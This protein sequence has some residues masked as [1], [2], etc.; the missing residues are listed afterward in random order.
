MPEMSDYLNT[1][2]TDKMRESRCDAKNFKDQSS[3]P[4]TC[5]RSCL[6]SLRRLKTTTDGTFLIG[7]QI[8]FFTAA[9][10]HEAFESVEWLN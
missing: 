10:F 6:L 4:T 7:W 8:R 1:G 3:R 2:L 9:N 5:I